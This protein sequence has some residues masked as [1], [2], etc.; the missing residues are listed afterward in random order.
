MVPREPFALNF[1]NLQVQFDEMLLTSQRR[2]QFTKQSKEASL[3]TSRPSSGGAA[4]S[5]AVADAECVAL[6]AVDETHFFELQE[7]VS[8]G[9]PAPEAKAALDAVGAGSFQAAVEWFLARRSPAV[10]ARP[11]VKRSADWIPGGT[12]RKRGFSD[13]AP[14][15]DVAKG[16][17][18]LD[19]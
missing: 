9:F 17:I 2:L 15:G 18:F 3:S 8:M 16:P 11:G 19:D 10:Q 1:L 5:T 14:G 4:G 13:V 12:P 7:L 6:Q